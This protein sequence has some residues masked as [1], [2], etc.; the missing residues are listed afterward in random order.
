MKV[1]ICG[2]NKKHISEVKEKLKKHNLTYATSKPD[3]VFS[4]GGDGT[5]FYAERKF[6]SVPKLLIR[7]K[8]FRIGGERYSYSNLNHILKKIEE[9]KYS[10]KENMKLEVKAKNKKLICVNDITIRNKYPT[11]A[12]RFSVNIA[13]KMRHLKMLV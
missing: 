2:L 7:N 11:Y 9:H 4:L 10:I 13:I 12:I 5:Y 1:A 8:S 6:P 3:L